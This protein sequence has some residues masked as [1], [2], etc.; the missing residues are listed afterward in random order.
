MTP[1]PGRLRTIPVFTALA[2][3]SAPLS[4]PLAAQTAALAPAARAALAEPANE[5]DAI[6]V[7]GT[8]ERGAVLGDIPPDQQLRPADIRA[9]GAGSIAD[10][11]SE[12]GSQVRSDRGRGGEAP[13][14]LLNGRRIASF[15]EI[16]NL[17]PEALARVDILPEEVGLKYGFTADQK[18]INFVLR[19]RFRAFTGDIDAGGPTAGERQDYK[20]SGN[21]LRIRNGKRLSLETQLTRDTAL[22]ESDRDIVSAAPLRPFDLTGNITSTLTGAA[23]DPALS[24]LAGT[25][26]TVAAVPAGAAGAAP[27]L[28][29]FVP[30]ANAPNVTDITRYRTLLPDNKALAVAGS[31]ATSIFGNVPATISGGI[32]A[33]HTENQQGLPGVALILPAGNPYSPFG[34]AVVVNRFGTSPLL[35]ANDSWTGRAG[36]ALNGTVHNWTWSMTSTY[37]HAE[38]NTL[39]DRSLNVSA[40]QSRILADDPA[41][42][43]FGPDAVAGTLVQDRAHSNTDS[44]DANLLLAGSLLPLP[45]G[46]LTASFKAGGQTLSLRS[47]ATRFGIEQVTSLSRRQ[48]NFQGSFDLPLTSRRNELLSAIGDLSVNFN[49][50]LDQLSDFGS[51]VTTGY[52]INWKPVKALSLI[53]SVTNQEGA[54]TIQQLGNPQVVTPNVRVFDYLTG[55]TATISRL[56]GG[57]PDL[58]VDHRRVFK[59]GATLKPFEARDLTLTANFIKSHIRNQIA[60]FP[61]ATAELEAAF[62]ER[63]VRDEAGQLVSIDNRPVNFASYDREELRWGITFSQPLKASA[64]DQAL[65][66][67]RRAAFEARRALEAATPGNRP[68]GPPGGASGS[69]PGGGGPGGGGRTGGGFGGRGGLD[70]RFQMSVFH[71]WHF[72]DQVLIRDGVPALDLLNGSAIGSTGGQPRHEVEVRAGVG[73]SGLG[74]RLSFNWQSGTQV[75]ADPSGATTSPGDLSFSDLA[76]INLRLYADLGQRPDI[77][78]RAPWLR[79]TRISLAV[80]NVA[81]TRVNVRNSSGMVPTGYQRDLIDPVGRSLTLSVRKLFF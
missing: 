74:G 42:N 35:Q 66:A 7:T 54:P 57:N 13:V 37:N 70:G 39:T 14:V 69:G 60:S 76:T 22:L 61:T 16:Q 50:A 6:T 46:S 2:A 19:E 52:G 31:Y 40:A 32:T 24:A 34:E 67:S 38:S 79:G 1:G 56:D 29:A 8:R 20:G 81:D 71:T 15:A 45:A 27:P 17:P 41:T 11:L 48:G 51:L 33:A 10:L 78:K 21:Y 68:D 36:L 77:V 4:A 25:P 30:G 80:N 53:A 23:I 62:P 3:L 72:Q 59:L 63:F 9:I 18:V 43:I 64:A 75:R 12:L 65:A 44:A 55:T 26:V 5:D 49:V 73:K 58:G 28:G 47:D